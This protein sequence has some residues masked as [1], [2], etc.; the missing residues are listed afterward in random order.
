MADR[1]YGVARGGQL[2]KDVTEGAST[3]GASAPVELR[4]SDTEYSNS[5]QVLAAVDAIRAY[6]KTKETR[7]IA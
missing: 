4:I 3:G 2:P 1:F 6:L 5:M 7:P